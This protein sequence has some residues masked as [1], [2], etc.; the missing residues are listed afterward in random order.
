MQ[1]TA[2]RARRPRRRARAHLADPRAATWSAASGCAA[3]A[4]SARS[5]SA[6]TGRSSRLAELGAAFTTGGPVMRRASARRPGARS[7]RRPRV[8][9]VKFAS[10]DGCQLT[11][12][13]LED[14]LLAH[15]RAVRHRRVRRGDVAPL[16]RPVRRAL[17]R[18]LHLHARAGSRRSLRLRAVTKTLVTIGA[19]ATAGGIQALRNCVRARGRSAPR[20][21]PRPRSSTRSPIA[22][23]DRRLRRR[24]TPSCA[25]AR[26]TRVSCV[27]LLTAARHRPSPAAAGRGGLPGVQAARHRR[28][29]WSPAAIACL[30]PVT[31]TGC[32]ALCP[33]FGRG[34]YGCFGPREDANVTAL[35]GRRRRAGPRATADV[36]RACS[37]DSP[38][39]RARSARSSTPAAARPARR[40]PGRR[41]PPEHASEDPP[42]SD[43]RP[44]SPTPERRRSRFQVAEPDPGRGRRLAPPASSGTARSSRRGSRSSRRRATSSARRRPDARRGPRHRRAHLRHLPGRLP[45]ERGPRLRG[46]C[47]A[48][49]SSPAVARPAPAALLRRVDREPRAA[50][51]P[52]PRPRLPR[53][54]ERRSSSP[55][56]TA[57]LVEDGAAAQADRQPPGRARRRPADPPG[58]RARRRLLPRADPV[59]R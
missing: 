4:S 35:A 31:Q 57:S 24:S 15:H 32:G 17:R 10:C 28:A 34:C 12:L 37:P 53:L 40:P 11:I 42:M 38:A 36:G 19:C 51:L 21:I 59:A 8:G 18:G 23:P 46:R 56:T 45:D 26:S 52:A 39:R 3:T 41:D 47:S 2:G 44:E 50:R 58:Q 43:D 33:A 22:S 48:S 27:E 25:A 14:E 20:S 7:P 13:D 1:A 6:A 49:R 54:P 55:A 29:S 16:V 5:S 30:G 9:V